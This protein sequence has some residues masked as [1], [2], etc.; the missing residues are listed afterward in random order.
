MRVQVFR[1]LVHIFIAVWFQRTTEIIAVDYNR[2]REALGGSKVKRTSYGGNGICTILTGTDT[3]MQ[4]S[5]GTGTTLTGTSTLRLLEY[6]CTFGTDTSLTGTSTN[7]RSL[8]DLSGI[9]ILVQGHARLLIT[10]LRSLMRIVF[11]PTLGQN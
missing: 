9:S 2:C 4:W 8:Q 5:N 1:C 7:M 6:Q 10:T 3:H 11:K